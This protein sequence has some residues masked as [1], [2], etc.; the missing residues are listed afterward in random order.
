MFDHLGTPWTADISRPTAPIIE[1]AA[2]AALAGGLMPPPGL[3]MSG[4][5]RTTVPRRA[6][7][8]PGADPESRPL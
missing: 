6:R 4:A 1:E 8:E 2:P 5:R 7:L 3:Y